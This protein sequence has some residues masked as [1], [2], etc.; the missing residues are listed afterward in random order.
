MTFFS[1]ELSEQLTSMGCKSESGC[2]FRE[3]G[4][5]Y[6]DPE[7]PDPN[8]KES[9]AA[10]HPWDFLGPSAQ[11]RANARIVWG[12]D[13]VDYYGQRL[14]FLRFKFYQ[15]AIELS[16]GRLELVPEG[17][18]T[19]SQVMMEGINLSDQDIKTTPPV[20]IIEHQLKCL[21]F[22]IPFRTHSR[23]RMTVDGQ[24]SYEY[25]RHAMLDAE[26]QEAYLK[27]TMK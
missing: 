4:S 2:W 3:D 11:A 18:P 7:C 24:K 26:D 19:Y 10:F 1:K 20:K 13:D 6:G 22:Q 15:T 8:Y 12:E 27:E 9:L 23:G 5:I 16:N 17:R 21:G 14:C 25:H